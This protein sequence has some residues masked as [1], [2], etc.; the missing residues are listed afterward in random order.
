VKLK[1][2]LF[3]LFLIV[4]CNYNPNNSTY[5]APEVKWTT[6]DEHPSIDKCDEYEIEIDRINCFNSKLSNLIYSNINLGDILVS[7]KLNDTVFLSLL[8]DEQGKLSLLNIENKKS[9]TNEIPNI[10][11]I[12]KNSLNNIPSL[13]PATKTNF[14]IP[15]ST[16]FQL[17]LILKSN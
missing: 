5:K 12:I 6:K 2:V 3:L 15:V 4:G 13:Y 9:I 10:D 11:L 14:G 8:V 7:K 17:P 16:K 1:Q